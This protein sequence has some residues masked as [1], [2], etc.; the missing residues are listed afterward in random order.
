MPDFFAPS[1]TKVAQATPTHRPITPSEVN[2]RAQAIKD[3]QALAKRRLDLIERAV[4]A[5]ERVKSGRIDPETG[6][7]TGK[8][9]DWMGDKEMTP[10]DLLFSPEQAGKMGVKG[11]MALM[12]FFLPSN[13][14]VLR[15]LRHGSPHLFDKFG[16]RRY[17][18]W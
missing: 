15:Q 12:P 7:W 10:L 11:L 16:A 18:N 5:E 4:L 3:K 17:Q 6:K 1:S 13:P 9:E 2:A 14:Q 8:G